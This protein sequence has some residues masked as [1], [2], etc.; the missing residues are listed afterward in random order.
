MRCDNL[1]RYIQAQT[2]LP[3]FRRLQRLEEPTQLWLACHSPYH[4]HLKAQLLPRRWP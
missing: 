4:T 3:G 2:E 1:M